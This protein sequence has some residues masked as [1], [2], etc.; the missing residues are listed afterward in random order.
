MRRIL[1]NEKNEFF[2]LIMK[3]KFKKFLKKIIKIAF[4]FCLIIL[5]FVLLIYVFFLKDLPSINVLQNYK[6]SLPSKV[7]DINE[8]LIDEFFIEKRIYTPYSDIPK[9]MIN[10]IIAIEDNNFYNHWGISPVGIIRAF[11]TNIFYKRYKQGGSTITQQ[12]AKLMF[13]NREKKISRKI[14]E[15]FLSIKLEYKCSKSEILTMYLNHIYLAHGIYGVRLASEFYFGKGLNELSLDEI[16]LLAGMPKA[17]EVYSPLKNEKKAL[18]RRNLV[19]SR[20]LDMKFITEEE[21]KEAIKK[22]I[23]LN[24]NSKFEKYASYFIEQIRIDLEKKYGDSLYQA[25]LQIYTTLDID[26]QIAAFNAIEERLKKFD[27]NKKLEIT[28]SDVLTDI[29]KETKLK[30]Y[31]NIQ[32]ALIALDVKTGQIRALVGGRDFKESQFNRVFQAKR[33][34][35]SSFKPIIYTAAI[36]N[37]IPPNYILDDKPVIYYYDKDWQRVGHKLDFSD[38]PLEIMEKLRPNPNLNLDS[39]KKKASINSASINNPYDPEQIW[40][41]RNYSNKFYG[42]VTMRT[43]L[44]KS[45]NIPSIVLLEKIGPEKATHYAKI[46]G[47]DSVIRPYLSMVLGAFE[48]TPLELAR[49][50]NTIANSGI[51]TTPYMITKICDNSGQLLEEFYPKEEQVISKQTSYV[52]TNLLRGV[53][54]N[55]TGRIANRLKIPVAAKTG[56]TN[57]STDTWFIGFSPNIVTCVWVGYD[58]LQ[59]IG[60][61]TGATLA[62][63]IW[64]DFMKSTIRENEPL[65]FQTPNGIVFVPIDR[66]TGLKVVQKNENSFLESF[67]QGTEPDES[68]IY[69]ELFRNDFSDDIEDEEEFLELS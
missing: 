6:P 33:Q 66:I 38:V 1:F 64:V 45:L 62:G 51:K 69:T 22:P 52:M 16:A 35:G 59:S 32:G 53:V 30:E 27:E 14:K 44:E 25:G 2:R 21:Y 23:I 15:V 4:S 31:E 7:Y 34:A 29:E 12:L 26:L 63:P 11:V 58:K 3:K 39:D 65:S 43:A 67:I 8:K 10:A 60:K 49:S 61:Y 47:I 17:P 20:M 36:D 9:S 56:T 13:L 24:V 46:L 54:T 37:N 19:L 5:L 55:G 48:I 41:P 18:S 40:I 28:N 42:K 57:D 50:Y 68:S